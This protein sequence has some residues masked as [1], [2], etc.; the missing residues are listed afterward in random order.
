MKSS[1]TP[2]LSWESANSWRRWRHPRP[3]QKGSCPSGL[4]SWLAHTPWS[5]G[6]DSLVAGACSHHRPGLDYDLL[7]ALLCEVQLDDHVLVAFLQ[8]APDIEHHRDQDD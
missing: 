2:F 5:V 8:V 6:G 1:G 3:C 4:P 7:C